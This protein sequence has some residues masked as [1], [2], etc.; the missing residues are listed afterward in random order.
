VSV[1]WHDVVYTTQNQDGGLR[2]DYEN[3]RDCGKLFRQYTLLKQPDADAVYDLIMATCRLGRKN[4]I[5][6][7]LPTISISSWIWI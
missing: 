5:M 7:G 1:F 3:V 4:S 6:L 2:P